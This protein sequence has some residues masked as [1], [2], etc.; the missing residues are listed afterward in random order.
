MTGAVYDRTT[1]LGLGLIRFNFPNWGDDMN[2]NSQ[3]MDSAFAVFGIAISG[4]WEND[5]AY[6]QGA[7]VAD[8]DEN[9]LYRANTSH[10]SASSGSFL[11]DRT[12]HPSYWSLY[13]SNIKYRGDWVTATQYFANETFTHDDVWYIV[14]V[15]HV[16][17]TFA[18]DLSNDLFTMFF[19]PTSANDAAAA[20]A[21]AAAASATAAAG[22]ATAASGSA[23]SASSSA[24]AASGSATTAN[25]K[26]SE[27]AASATAA[28]GSATGASTSA[29][30]AA[31]SSGNASS[32]A[33]TAS[34]AQVAA[35][36]S[37]T[38]A[39]NA[40]NNLVQGE[41][42]GEFITPGAGQTYTIVLQARKKFTIT[43]TITQCV[44][45]TAAFQWR[46]NGV[47][48]GGSA[49]SVSTT[50]QS[51]DRTSANVVNAGDKVTIACT[52]NAAC[53]QASWTMETDLD[54]S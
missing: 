24:T 29:S 41:M 3:I 13:Q 38:Q 31:T 5:T 18:T 48:V 6:I 35:S 17:G 53:V 8:T 37:A 12:A 52:A 28:A 50:K 40:R 36:A 2:R 1:Q 25:T 42:S 23:S 44:S 21:A 45:G 47:S 49:N 32:S 34:T 26:A 4:P 54:V 15:T 14:T 9:T 27:A 19:D 16:S 20:S 22:S 10:T 11:D 33:G 30:N 39:Q 51:I 46:I 7:I 43:K